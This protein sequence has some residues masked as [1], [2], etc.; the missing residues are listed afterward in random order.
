MG[1]REVNKI[2]RVDEPLTLIISKLGW[3][4]GYPPNLLIKLGSGAG[5]YITPPPHS[6]LWEG[7]PRPPY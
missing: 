6:Y 2:H 4:G 1:L 3:G 5:G 7:T